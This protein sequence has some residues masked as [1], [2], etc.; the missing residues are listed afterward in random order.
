[1]VS[2]VVRGRQ[3]DRV[4]RGIERQ[5]LVEREG[6]LFV[7]S[8]VADVHR[9][10]TIGGDGEPGNGIHLIGFLF[11]DPSLKD[12]T[13]SIGS[14]DAGARRSPV[15]GLLRPVQPTRCLRYAASRGHIRAERRFA[16]NRADAA[17]N[18]IGALP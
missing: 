6:F 9:H 16:A 17:T 11:C 7:G 12:G 2:A 1:M 18:R 3:R 14:E 4:G 5:R 13:R 15:P 8:L 10:F